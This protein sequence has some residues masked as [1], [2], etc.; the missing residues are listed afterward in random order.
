MSAPPFVNNPIRYMHVLGMWIL[1]T[2]INASQHKNTIF[3]TWTK[4]IYKFMTAENILKNITVEDNTWY[5]RIMA[6]TARWSSM[7]F[8]FICPPSARAPEPPRYGAILVTG[9]WLRPGAAREGGGWYAWP[10]AAPAVLL[11]KNESQDCNKYSTHMHYCSPYQL[12]TY[13]DILLPHL[14]Y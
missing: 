10:G 6:C 9:T 5:D 1:I 3:P 7:I 4:W 12:Y 8:S 14:I 13:H 11:R 2:L